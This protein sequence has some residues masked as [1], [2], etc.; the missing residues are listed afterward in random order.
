M[1][2]SREEASSL[3]LRRA[4]IPIREAPSQDSRNPD[5]LSE[6]PP[7]TLLTE[8]VLGSVPF[9]IVPVLLSFVDT[10]PASLTYAASHPLQLVRLMNPDHLSKQTCFL[11]F[12]LCDSAALSMCPPTQIATHI[13]WLI[14]HLSL[15]LAPDSSMNPHKFFTNHT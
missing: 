15:N 9:I 8:A 12:L 11:A 4:L 3:I 5:S 6:A 2:E 10:E 1:A 13:L 14:Y 7:P